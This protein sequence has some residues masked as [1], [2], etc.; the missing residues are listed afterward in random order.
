MTVLAVDRTEQD[1]AGQGIGFPREHR[2][3]NS[4]L[5][6]LLLIIIIII[7]INHHLFLLTSMWRRR[8]ESV[9]SPLAQQP[10]KR[11]ISYMIAPSVVYGYWRMLRE[12]VSAADIM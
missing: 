4:L 9:A 6:L 5:L 12:R 8:G 1:G 7:I 2:S 3:S 10:A 11:S